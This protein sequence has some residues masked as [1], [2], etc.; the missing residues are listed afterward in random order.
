VTEDAH[1]AD[2]VASPEKAAPSR[3]L[4][5]PADTATSADHTAFGND[6]DGGHG[7][8]RD[9]AGL[10]GPRVHSADGF[11]LQEG[12]ILTFAQ[13][14]VALPIDAAASD[15]GIAAYPET[16]GIV[17]FVR[18]SWNIRAQCASC[19]ERN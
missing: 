11:S 9:V 14:V 17:G 12:R 5:A 4:G 18:C 16:S 8:A 2:F 10:T 15:G 13:T 1:A 7:V 3:F 6:A 19:P